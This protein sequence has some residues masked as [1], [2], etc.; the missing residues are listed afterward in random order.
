MGFSGNAILK[1]A[2]DLPTKLSIKNFTS[3]I[4]NSLSSI[5][6][7]S[8]E[9]KTAAPVSVVAAE[10]SDIPTKYCLLSVN[11]IIFSICSFIFFSLVQR[12]CR[13]FRI[14]FQN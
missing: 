12:G 5:I 6:I 7:F 9:S 2:F 1:I 4:V 13:Y 14:V 10:P 8:F 3:S 11:F